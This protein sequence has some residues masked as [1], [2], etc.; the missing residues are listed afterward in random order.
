[1]SKE[2]EQSTDFGR[3]HL[4]TWW[5]KKWTNQSRQ[6]M[7]LDTGKPNVGRLGDERRL[8]DVQISTEVLSPSC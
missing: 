3:I 8:L 1:M 2:F 5:G 7:P 6:K 4:L